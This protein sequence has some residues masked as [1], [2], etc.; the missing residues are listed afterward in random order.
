MHLKH[1]IIIILTLLLGACA[2]VGN[3][4]GG[5]R[6]EDPP[7]LLR[8]DPPNGAVNVTKTDIT[9]YFNELINV[10]DAFSKVVMSPAGR[11]PRISTQGRR[12][13]IRFD[14]LQPNTTY[15]IDFADA[16]EDNN[17]ANPLQHFAYTFSTGPTLDTLRI[18]GMVLN[19]RDL[20]PQQG[21]LVGVHSNLN[22]TAVLKTP[23]DR[24]AKTDDRGQ[25]VIRGLAPGNYRVF[26]LKD[27]DANNI[28][29]S[30]EEDFAFY[31]VAVTPYTSSSVVQDTLFTKL[32]E[33][34]S[35]KNRTRTLYFPNDILLRTFNSLK[36]AQYISKYERNDSNRLFLK[37]GTKCD[38]LPKITFVDFPHYRPSSLE[39]RHELDSI[40]MWLS[41]E[42]ASVDSLRLAV[43]YTRLERDSMPKFITD[44][45]LY[46]K[47]SLPVPKKGKKK[48]KISAADSIAAITTSLKMTS[49]SQL[50]I[51][52]PVTVE[53]DRPLQRLDTAAIHLS[54][55][56]DSVWKPLNNIKVYTADSLQ[57]R[58]LSINYPWDYNTSYKLEIDSLAGVD[59]YGRPTLPLEQEFK[60]RDSGDYCSLTF[61]VSG[62]DGIPLF[63]EL[64]EPSDRVVRT[65]LVKNGKAYFPFLQPGKYYARVIEDFNGNGIFD[66]G[67]YISGLQPELAFYYPKVINI[68][69][70]W[71]K[72]EDWDIFETAVDKMKPAQLVRNKPKAQKRGKKQ[73]TD[74]SLDDEEEDYF[75]PSANPFEEG[76]GKK[77]NN[78]NQLR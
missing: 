8:A 45:L 26:A 1:L 29:N 13:N 41:P 48:P 12:V 3:P 59:L 42:M 2:N 11:L 54:V 51:Y 60:T 57:P 62:D 43:Q 74:N 69:K 35:V 40:T 33:I 52:S 19:A 78:R 68:K 6:D 46:I 34:D 72:E 47:K 50:E 17:E 44:T 10:K 67:D 61:N 20:E 65:A 71:D 73:Q 49:A 27:N 25:F 5:P 15:T 36:R 14:S 31:D 58:I 55:K 75:D 76:G 63:V 53:F 23:F 21:I 4:S 24:V 28:Y 32:G 22:D 39:T 77:K 16:I 30:E 18:A 37:M 56:V 38:T 70:N 64:L 66:T 9:L 7:R